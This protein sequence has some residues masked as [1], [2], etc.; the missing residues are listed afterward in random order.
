MHS[1]LCI[2]SAACLQAV[3]N[4]VVCIGLAQGLCNMATQVQAAGM[5]DRIDTR[6][7][8]HIYLLDV[9]LLLSLCSC[10]CLQSI[11]VTAVCTGFVQHVRHSQ[12]QPAASV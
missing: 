5:S 11:L 3:L 9:L 10:G 8:M 1:M 4:T 12:V 7:G 6:T 2:R